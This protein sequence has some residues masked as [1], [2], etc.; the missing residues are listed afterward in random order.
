MIL[1][2]EGASASSFGFIGKKINAALNI[3]LD[4]SPSVE[5]S[6]DIGSLNHL[7]PPPQRYFIPVRAALKLESGKGGT[8]ISGD[9]SEPNG[10]LSAKITG[11]AAKAATRNG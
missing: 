1:D 7:A 9:I 2:F 11:D 4:D 3:S 8:T 10:K 6:V 5:G